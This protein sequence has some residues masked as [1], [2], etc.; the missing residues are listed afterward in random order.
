MLN[1]A[2]AMKKVLYLFANTKTLVLT[3]QQITKELVI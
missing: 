1:I 2:F 3:L